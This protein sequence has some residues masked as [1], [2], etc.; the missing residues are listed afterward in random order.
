[1]ARTIRDITLP[2]EWSKTAAGDNF[3][4][5]KD[6]TILI[7]STDANLEVLGQSS[8]IFMDGT[9]KAAPRI[10]SQLFTLHGVFREHVVPLAYCLLADKLRST[11]YDM[12][13]SLK[14]TMA[15]NNDN[16][17]PDVIISDFE[18][19]MLHCTKLINVVCI[20]V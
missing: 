12:F 10:F 20:T 13:G 8:V 14:Q 11:Y 6:D 7:L 5:H 19:G 16:L 15:N 3:V 17:T 2:G 9:F 18:S 4:V 1:M